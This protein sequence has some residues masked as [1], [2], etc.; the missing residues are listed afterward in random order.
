MEMTTKKLQVKHH[1]IDTEIIKMKNG[2]RWKAVVVWNTTIMS[3]RGDGYRR[4]V[5]DGQPKSGFAY[6]DEAITWA[7]NMTDE[8]AEEAVAK[9]KW[10]TGSTWAMSPLD[11]ESWDK[12]DAYMRTCSKPIED[13]FWQQKYEQ[14]LRML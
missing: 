6:E 3:S 7:N 14:W 13:R 2:Y 9:I 10:S 5:V 12:Y 11:W 8:Q 1:D 4:L